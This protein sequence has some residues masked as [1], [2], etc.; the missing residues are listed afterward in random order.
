MSEK[1]ENFDTAFFRIY[2]KK[3]AA[4]EVTFASLGINKEDFTS[5][6]MVPGFIFSEETI[7]NLKNTMKLTDE[8]YSRLMIAA[9][10]EER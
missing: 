6:C 4:E 10:Y 1:I 3:I 9:G 2:D 8:E 5:L 7:E